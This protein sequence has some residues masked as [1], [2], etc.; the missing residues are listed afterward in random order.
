MALNKSGGQRFCVWCNR[1][2]G[3]VNAVEAVLY[4][5]WVAIRA[6]ADYQPFFV[7]LR[8]LC[9]SLSINFGYNNIDAAEDC[10]GIGEHGAGHDGGHGRYV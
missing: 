4:S 8:V 10:H 5:F 9:G 3:S 6:F 1:K 2:N 7:F